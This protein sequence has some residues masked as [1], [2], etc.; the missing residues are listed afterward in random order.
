M[1]V[2]G[3]ALGSSAECI[4]CG[5]IDGDMKA[6]PGM[7]D[8]AGSIGAGEAADGCSSSSRGLPTGGH[9]TASLPP[10][11]AAAA[12]F[13]APETAMPGRLAAPVPGTGGMFPQAP[14]MEPGTGGMLPVAPVMEPAQGLASLDHIAVST[15][16]VV[17]E[18]GM[19]GA[20]GMPGISPGMPVVP[21]IVPGMPPGIVPSMEGTF[22]TAPAGTAAG[23]Y[24][25]GGKPCTGAV[26]QA[27]VGAAGA[28]ALAP[29]GRRGA[30]I[31]WNMP[32]PMS[33]PMQPSP[34]QSLFGTMTT[35]RTVSESAL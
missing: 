20:V 29:G 31:L 12:G 28:T 35:S 32:V 11:A 14:V 30:G 33:Q 6:P 19:A 2:P 7:G 27:P 18:T 1:G 9:C 3:G 24:A 15:R 8:M 17:T 4:P 26:A 10:A 34:P 22:G 21:G 23:G 5:N 13:H 16:W 25:G